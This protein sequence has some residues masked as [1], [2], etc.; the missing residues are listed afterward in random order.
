MIQMLR[1]CFSR[2]AESSGGRVERGAN[3]LRIEIPKE[4]VER[5][6]T[7]TG[8][9]GVYEIG[10]LIGSGAFGSVY[11]VTC[12]DSP[13]KEYVLKRS[14]Y[15]NR[16]DK[17][18]TLSIE[19]IKN[20]SNALEYLNK[21]DPERQVHI[22]RKIES[23]E[24]QGDIAL[25]LEYGG[26]E[27]FSVIDKEGAFNL[28]LTKKVSIQMLDVLRFLKERDIAHLDISLAN[29]L[30]NG[31]D[32]TLIDFGNARKGGSIT[33]KE[34]GT[35]DYRSPECALERMLTG[36][37]DVWALACVLFSV[38]TA[39]SAFSAAEGFS[40]SNRALILSHE[41][42]LQ[43]KY[44]EKF[45]SSPLYTKGLN[46]EQIKEYEPASIQNTITSQQK[47]NGDNSQEVRIFFDVLDQMFAF[48]P[49]T[50]ISPEEGLRELLA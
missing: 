46:S 21:E 34:I 4:V 20:E 29:I 30:Y 16:R 12:E 44:P 1:G 17:A 36:A 33:H 6:L 49:E 47:K 23:L 41:G 27:L 5:A 37:A 3:P 24:V 40:T 7:I 45:Q 38:Y 19:N 15:K 50:R 25:V 43:R 35:P 18:H 9:K 11:Q 10:R 28:Y 31:R 8:E 48:D 13:C 2:T 32:F 39:Y 42:F 22:I 26:E 14:P